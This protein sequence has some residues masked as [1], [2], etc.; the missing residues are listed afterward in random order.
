MTTEDITSFV[1]GQDSF[2]VAKDFDFRHI[3][4]FK[5]TQ[6]FVQVLSSGKISLYRYYALMG[7][8]S[9]FGKSTVT[10]TFLKKGLDIVH[11]REKETKDILLKHI[12]DFPELHNIVS[13]MNKEGINLKKQIELYNAHFLPKAGI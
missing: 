2:T 10:Y 4:Y 5:I 12:K 3:F 11:V 9:K 6:D 13:Q 8:G 7:S 1:M